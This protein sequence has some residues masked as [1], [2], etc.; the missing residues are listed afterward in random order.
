MSAPASN[1][2]HQKINPLAGSEMELPSIRITD[3]NPD[4]Q[5]TKEAWKAPRKPNRR[6]FGLVLV[7]VLLLVGLVVGVSIA[8]RVV[9]E[10]N[11][12]LVFTRL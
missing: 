6:L 1:Q 10:R 2:K 3:T 7:A 11:A 12:E 8:G 9:L 4:A 5:R